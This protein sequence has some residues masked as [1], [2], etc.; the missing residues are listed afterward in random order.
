MLHT[1][2][3]SFSADRGQ[4]SGRSCFKASW[5]KV[6]ETPIST[7]KQGMVEYACHLTYTGDIS[8]SITVRP[9]PGKTARTY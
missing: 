6:H 4:R 8:T 9:A 5:E 1:G 2:L 3:P 7:N